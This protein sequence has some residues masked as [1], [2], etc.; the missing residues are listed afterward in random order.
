MAVETE[1]EHDAI[2][3]PVLPLSGSLRAASANAA[4]PVID[5]VSCEADHEDRA[6]T[7]QK[8]S[9]GIDAGSTVAC[10]TNPWFTTSAPSGCTT[11]M[12]RRLTVVSMLGGLV[13]GLRG[14]RAETIAGR[15][16]WLSRG[17][18]PGLGDRSNAGQ[19]VV[20]QPD[21]GRGRIGARL[22]RRFHARDGTAD[23]GMGQAERQR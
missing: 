23:S 12:I 19:L 22:L 5:L 9:L 10:R 3:G 7:A 15:H 1:D 11:A 8:P 21:L 14:L 20:A 6:A 2:G 16:D 18:S 13:T 4:D 17:L